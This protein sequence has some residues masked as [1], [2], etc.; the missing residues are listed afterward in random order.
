[1]FCQEPEHPGSAFTR[2]ETFFTPQG[3]GENPD[4]FQAFLQTQVCSEKLLV[5]CPAVS[6][7]VSFGFK[8]NLNI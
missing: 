7:C 5:F 1:M 2:S 6:F 8:K 4:Y 3:S